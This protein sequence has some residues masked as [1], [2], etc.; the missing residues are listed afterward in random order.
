MPAAAVFTVLSCSFV[1]ALPPVYTTVAPDSECVY[2]NECSGNFPIEA[3]DRAAAQLTPNSDVA[4]DD[5]LTLEDS[6]SSLAM[7]AP[8]EESVRMLV[9]GVGMPAHATIEPPVCNHSQPRASACGRRRVRFDAT[10]ETECA[11]RP[12]RTVRQQREEM[13][14]RAKARKLK[15]VRVHMCISLLLFSFFSAVVR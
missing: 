7:S 1:C 14:R 10:V 2:G 8:E 3:S 4:T 5:W 11:G 12:R 13:G 9:S 15:R 6:S